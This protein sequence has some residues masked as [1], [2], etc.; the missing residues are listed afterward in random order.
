ML[1]QHPLLG[2]GLAALLALG[3]VVALLGLNGFVAAALGALA[4]FALPE[5]GMRVRPVRAGARRSPLR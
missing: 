2:Y 1:H 3:A 4:W 5:H